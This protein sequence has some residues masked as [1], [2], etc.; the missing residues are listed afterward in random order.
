MSGGGGGGIGSSCGIGSRSD[1]NMMGMQQVGPDGKSPQDLD[2]IRGR[3]SELKSRLS[4]LQSEIRD[5][6]QQ[7]E[8]KVN[9]LMHILQTSA[10]PASST[11]QLSQQLSMTQQQPSAAASQ[12][13]MGANGAGGLSAGLLHQLG[14][15]AGAGLGGGAA[16][17]ANTA[18]LLQQA[19]KD[20]LMGMQ[21]PSGLNGMV[22]MGGLGM[23]AG[24]GGMVGGLGGLGGGAQ[25]AK[26]MENG[27]CVAGLQN[28]VAGLQHLLEAAQRYSVDDGAQGDPAAQLQAA[29]QQH[30]Q[31]PPAKRICVEAPQMQA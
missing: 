30:Q 9:I 20:A 10:A 14:S 26:N 21:Q 1:D 6:N 5:Y 16:S 22:G 27:S 28:G 4:T 11:Q 3:V 19:R 12:Q 25:V 8:Q 7:M 17:A 24:L 15:G 2:T 18:N 13:G 23:G 31:M 29:N